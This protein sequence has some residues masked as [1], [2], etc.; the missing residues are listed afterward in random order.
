[1]LSPILGEIARPFD[2]V[3]PVLV[4]H[5]ETVDAILM[6]PD[7]QRL[8]SLV[9]VNVQRDGALLVPCG[10]KDGRLLAIGE[11]GPDS[12][13]EIVVGVVPNLKF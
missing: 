8:C 13:H 6:R 7:R 3:L 9:L 11:C 4:S 1:M 10:P 12:C 5:P 2:K